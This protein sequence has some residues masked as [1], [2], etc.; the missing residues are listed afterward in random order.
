MVC[1][2]RPSDPSDLSDLSDK[3]R[4]LPVNVA[5][6]SLEELRLDYEDFLRQRG[7]RLWP[8]DDA[9]GQRFIAAR[10]GTLDAVRNWIN[11]EHFSGRLPVPVPEIAANAALILIRVS[12]SLLR[13]QIARLAAD[14]ELNGG[15][16]ERL[17]RVRSATRGR[18][19]LSGHGGPSAED[20]S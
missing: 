20:K 8:A 6:A 2:A 16:T 19:G 9:A 12:S 11:A 14:F 17:Y 7:Y 4:G 5:R 18:S 13:R 10:C 15:F 3:V 1:I